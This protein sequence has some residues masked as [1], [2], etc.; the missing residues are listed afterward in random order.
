MATWPDDTGH[1]GYGQAVGHGQQVPEYK[2][3]NFHDVLN[4]THYW[5]R[6]DIMT[7][8]TVSFKVAMDAEQKAA[9]NLKE[10]KF[11]CSFEGVPAS[12]IQRHAIANQVVAWQSQIRNNWDKFISGELPKTVTFGTPLFEGKR[13]VVTRPITEQDIREYL[14]GKTPEEIMAFLNPTQ[15]VAESEEEE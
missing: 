13:T 1:M 12:L 15:E 4:M 3:G 8:T 5:E 10:V 6:M 2:D 7:T 11:E 9:K 14:K